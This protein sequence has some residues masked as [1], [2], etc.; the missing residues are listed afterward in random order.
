LGSGSPGRWTRDCNRRAQNHFKA[1]RELV[2]RDACWPVQIPLPRLS[3]EMSPSANRSKGLLLDF[4]A[5]FHIGPSSNRPD[6]KQS[7][8]A[9]LPQ[10][11]FYFAVSTVQ[12]PWT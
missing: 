5:L 11:I 9:H 4:P 2:A 10:P 3:L 7:D 6:L 1:S 8:F 12:T